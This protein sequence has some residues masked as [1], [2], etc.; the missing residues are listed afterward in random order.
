MALLKT[1]DYLRYCNGSSIQVFEPFILILN[2]YTYS[3][4]IMLG[5]FLVM[6][7]SPFIEGHSIYIAVRSSRRSWYAGIMLFILV[8]TVLYYGVIFLST[9]LFSIRTA[10]IKNVW[11]QSLYVLGTFQPASALEEYGLSFSGEDILAYLT[12]GGTFL[13][14]F[15]LNALY[16]VF[17]IYV[18]FLINLNGRWILGNVVAILIHLTGTVLIKSVYSLLIGKYSLLAHSQ[19]VFHH[20]TEAGVTDL[21]KSLLL[22][23]ALLFLEIVSG[24]FLVKKSAFVTARGDR[25]A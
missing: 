22:F 19:L 13:L 14:T 1:C 21:Y 25:E 10:Y 18:A 23:G 11:S 4:F 24:T 20:I 7:D 2:D 3:V 12:P 15:L 17:L 9:A 8:Q 6:V 16:S 5:L